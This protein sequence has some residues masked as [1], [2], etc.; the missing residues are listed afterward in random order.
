M[1][2]LH[3]VLDDKFIDMAL[4]EFEAVA[5]GSHETVILGARA[6]FRYLTQVRPRTVD[7]EGLVRAAMAPDVRSVIFHGLPGA[8]LQVLGRLPAGPLVIWLGW[9][10]DYY[11]LINDA[12]PEGLIQP[13]TASLLAKLR[14]TLPHDPVVSVL[15][16]ARPYRKPTRAALQRVDLFCPVMD[17]EYRL[18][19]QHQ[20]GFKARYLRWNYGTA[21]DDFGPGGPVA[22]A[23]GPDLLVGNSATPTNNH[24]ELFESIRKQ[25]NLDGRRLVAPL[26]YGDS[27][28]GRAVARR[29]QELFGHAFVALTDYVD[30]AQYIDT[31]SRCGTLVLN[32]LRQQALG[33]VYISAQLGARVFLN[34][35]CPMHGWLKRQG[36]LV[37][38]LDALKM[39]PLDAAQRVTQRRAVMAMI[40]RDVQRP[41]TRQLVNVALCEAPLPPE[42]D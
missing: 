22:E 38:D 31:L 36:L 18:V 42:I 17:V 13:A 27:V 8:H 35:R 7:V 14:P 12:F 10:Y 3:V 16:S 23:P 32:T 1:K 4:R 28:Y 30:K 20:P 34:R 2:I 24:L 41:R 11:G 21:E 40:G 29:G 39:D 25:V 5:P 33:N 26:S 6:P 19:R 37:G 15:A 9:G